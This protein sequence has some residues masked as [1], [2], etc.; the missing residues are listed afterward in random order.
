M[1]LELR[2]ESE[3][4]DAVKGMVAN[5]KKQINEAKRDKERITI[6]LKQAAKQIEFLKV[7]K[8]TMNADGNKLLQ[9]F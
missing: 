2:A 7:R 1:I 8:E 4:L 6:Q 3:L 5:Y 9:D